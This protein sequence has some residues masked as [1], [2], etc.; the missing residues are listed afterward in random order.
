MHSDE[1]IAFYH[2]NPRFIY[3]VHYLFLR[4]QVDPPLPKRDA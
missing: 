3:V 2:V 4:N 1:W